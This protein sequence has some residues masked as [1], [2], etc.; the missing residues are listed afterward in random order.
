M[1]TKGEEGGSGWIK[2]FQDNLYSMFSF[3]QKENYIKNNS[4]I[5]HYH[6]QEKNIYERVEQRQ[7]I[8][9]LGLTGVT[10]KDL[11]QV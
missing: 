1:I 3:V 7:K 10:A 5:K 6:S 4:K 11:S 2:K 9:I 8:C